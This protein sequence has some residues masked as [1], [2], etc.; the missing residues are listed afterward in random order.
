MSFEQTGSQPTSTNDA[1]S[2]GGAFSVLRTVS[3][4][5]HVRMYV[6][7]Q[8]RAY[9]RTVRG[10]AQYARGGARAQQLGTYVGAHRKRR[11]M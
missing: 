5:V 10:S 4:A 3:E 7:A 1:D 6:A 2:V 9:T 11:G 8:C